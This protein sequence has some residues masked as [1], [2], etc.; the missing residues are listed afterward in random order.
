[1]HNQDVVMETQVPILVVY[2]EMSVCLLHL[3]VCHVCDSS[4]DTFVFSQL[5]E[6]VSV[7]AGHVGG[8]TR[9]TVERHDLHDPAGGT[10]SCYI[11][12]NTQSSVKNHG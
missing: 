2:M 12:N 9:G 8:T 7:P 1:M 6:G 11:V 10:S 5:W 4:N 3:S